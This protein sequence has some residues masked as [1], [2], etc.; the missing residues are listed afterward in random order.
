MTLSTSYGFDYIASGPHASERGTLYVMVRPAGYSIAG[1]G[2][3]RYYGTLE[4]A[5]KAFER[6]YSRG[7][8]CSVITHP[9]NG[10]GFGFAVLVSRYAR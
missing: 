10:R 3:S 1:S 9:M 7:Y 8:E 6:L 4:A 5:Q 2:W